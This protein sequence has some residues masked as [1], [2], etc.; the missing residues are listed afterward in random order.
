MYG[1]EGLTCLE[2]ELVARKRLAGWFAG[3][4]LA[5]R[6]LRA[7][8]TEADIDR[9]GVELYDLLAN[10]TSGPPTSPEGHWTA[11]RLV[12]PVTGQPKTSDLA[13][14]VSEIGRWEEHQKTL[15]KE[16]K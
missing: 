14:V 12:G 2:I 9:T 16:S 7:V 6:S 5:L 1:L 3:C 10:A 11:V 13:K 15:A 8:Y 4:V